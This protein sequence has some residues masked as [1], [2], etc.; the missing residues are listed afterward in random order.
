M[1]KALLTAIIFVSLFGAGFVMAYEAIDSFDVII[2]VNSD[3]TLNIE[4]QIKYNFGL[5]D[6]H[7]IYRDIPIK[8]QARGGNYNLR[9]SDIEVVNENGQP[10]KF[11]ISSEG[12]YKRIKIGDADKY[13]TGQK[14]YIIRYKIGRAINYFQDYDEIYWNAT[15]NEWQVPILE[16]SAKVILPEAT[17]IQSIKADCF[18]GAIGSI[19]KC[20]SVIISSEPSGMIEFSQTALSSYQGLTIVVGVPKGVIT[21]PSKFSGAIEFLRDNLILFLPI[22]VFIIFFTIWWKK[23]KDPKGRKTIIAQYYAPDNLTPAEVGT[24]IDERVHNKDISAEIIHLAIKGYL[25]IKRNEKKI[26]FA[27]SIDY[28]LIKLK[29]DDGLQNDFDQ[30]LFKS[31]FKTKNEVK[32]SDLKKDFFKSVKEIRDLIY[33]SVTKNGYFVSHPNKA[34]ISY[35]SI[36]IIFLLPLMFGAGL[37]SKS[38]VVISLLITG[39]LIMV[40]G[41]IMPKRTLKGVLAKEHILGLKDYIET[42]EKERIKFHNAPQKNPELFEKLLP[43]AMVLGV[44][45]EWAVQFKDIY[46]NQPSWYEGPVGTGFN[47]IIFVGNLNFF[48]SAVRGSMAAPGGAAGGKSGFGGGGFSGGGFGGGGGGSW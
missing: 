23:G 42:A 4:E 1:K 29:E 35:I 13:V 22:V 18:A 14:T 48:A 44:E 27:K 24:I 17:N 3:S 19:E 30:K 21:P 5:A 26:L 12:E 47:S 32:L 8:Y 9:I 40:F 11:A 31:I 36:G 33:K 10:Y 2:K 46:L 41:L 15:G 25:K 7:G 39:L 38:T 6:K 16:S 45:K 20:S 28:E 43:M 37:L 34:R